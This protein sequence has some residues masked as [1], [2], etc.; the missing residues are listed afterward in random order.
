MNPQISEYYRLCALTSKVRFPPII[1]VLSENNKN[2]ILTNRVIE[3]M[4]KPMSGATTTTYAINEK[5]I[6]GKRSNAI[7][8]SRQK[9]DKLDKPNKL[10]IYY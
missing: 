6:G 2:I 3:L 1:N 8:G 10:V 7:D 4:Y 9:N 5:V